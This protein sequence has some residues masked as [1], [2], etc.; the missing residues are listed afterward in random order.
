MFV[1]KNVGVLGG[2]DEGIAK[3]RIWWSGTCERSTSLV[4]QRAMSYQCGALCLGKGLL[5][6][7]NRR[8]LVIVADKSVVSCLVG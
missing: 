1:L 8:V 5:Q 2:M 4:G 7:W 3:V 6:Q